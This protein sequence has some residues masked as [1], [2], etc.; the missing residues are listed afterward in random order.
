MCC[1]L[2]VGQMPFNVMG[3]SS[4]SSASMPG[5]GNCLTV[6][7]LQLMSH[8]AQQHQQQRPVYPPLDAVLGQGQLRAGY[9]QQQ[10][11]SINN[12]TVRP[13]P[14]M[15]GTYRGLLSSFLL[16]YFCHLVMH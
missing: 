4:S 13:Q 7:Q 12:N 2:E 14:L 16:T 10:P 5:A 6:E 8:L 11:L 15:R 1:L 3:P 9:M